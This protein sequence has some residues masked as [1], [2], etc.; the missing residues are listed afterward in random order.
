MDNGDLPLHRPGVSPRNPARTKGVDSARRVL[1]ILLQFSPKSPTLTVEQVQATYEISLPSA[2]RYVALLREMNLIEERAKG[3]YALSPHIFWL[4]R[5]AEASIDHRLLAQPVLERMRE[6]TGE[7]AQFMRRIN[8]TA[9]PVAVAESEHAISLSFRPDHPMPLYGG[10]A[11]KV[12]LADYP[13]AKRSHYLD[14]VDPPLSKR[15]RAALESDLERIRDREFAESSGEVDEGVWAVAA[16]VEVHGLLLGAV[17]IAA[18]S[19]RLTDERKAQISR[20]VKEGARDLR[21]R[22]LGQE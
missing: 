14:R 12:L 10:A 20:V 13:P 7:T 21:D 15:A 2:Y 4:A 19:F 8:D 18:P 1:Q 16:P 6:A 5:A 22:F 3:V 17:T 11:A 9:V